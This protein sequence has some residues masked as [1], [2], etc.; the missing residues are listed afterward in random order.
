MASQ[1][2]WRQLAVAPL[3]AFQKLK[4]YL[5]VYL[6][7]SAFESHV[8]FSFLPDDVQAKSQVFIVAPHHWTMSPHFYLIWV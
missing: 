6:Q 4:I 1:D 8:T 3:Q 7:V 5:F 2:D